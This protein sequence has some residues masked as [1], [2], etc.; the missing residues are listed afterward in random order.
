MM[1][2]IRFALDTSSWCDGRV[3]FLRVLSLGLYCLLSMS[4]ISH[5][6]LKVL[7][8]FLLRTPS[9]ITSN[10]DSIQLQKDIDNF[11]EWSQLWLLNTNNNK[12]KGIGIAIYDRSPLFYMLDGEQLNVISDQK[13][14]GIVNLNFIRTLHL[15]LE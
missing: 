7:L 8:P 15:L 9:S 14:L 3:V 2:K 6:W 10:L 4:T 5:R 13:D 1:P 12:C 11:L